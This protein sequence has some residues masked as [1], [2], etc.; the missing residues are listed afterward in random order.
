MGQDRT[1]DP[2]SFLLV[3]ALA[4]RPGG[5]QGHQDSGFSTLDGIELCVFAE[6]DS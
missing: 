6:E 2:G 5:H 3:G 1:E 4:K